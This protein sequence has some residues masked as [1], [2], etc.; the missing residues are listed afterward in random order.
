MLSGQNGTFTNFGPF[1]TNVF[2]IKTHF[3]YVKPQENHTHCNENCQKDKAAHLIRNF[4]F[5]VNS[6]R[7]GPNVRPFL[8]QNVC[9]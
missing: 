2:D 3:D 1:W 5:A 6:E 4:S 8:G 9:F 7:K